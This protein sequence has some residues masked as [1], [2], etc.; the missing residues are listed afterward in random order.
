MNIDLITMGEM[1]IDFIPMQKGVPLKQNKGFYRMPG[2]APANVAV[3]A[4]KLG[5]KSAF[6]GK[7]GDDP[8]GDLLVDTLAENRVVTDYIVKTD[9]AHTALAFVTLAENGERDFT[10][11][12]NPSADMLYIWEEVDQKALLSAKIFHHGSISL[13]D[14]P[15]KTTTFKMVK[16]ARD[17]GLL[18][19]YDPNLR[20]PLWS[21]KET[22]RRT[23]KQ[24]LE[25]ADILKISEDEL[26]FITKEKDIGNGIEKLSK[27][28]IPYIF[29]TA[30][31]EG[32][33]Y[34]SNNYQGHQP[35]IEVK[36]E[37]T[38]GA[39]DAFAAAILTQFI[40]NDV[41]LGEDISQEKLVSMVKYANVAGGIA[42]TGKGAIASL[43]DQKMVDKIIKGE[44]L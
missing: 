24:G 4:A 19:S 33:Y 17:N 6:F 10:F 43:P 12:R 39:G 16:M 32:T 1:L 41:K 2:G 28:K 14:E 38:T 42:T 44:D 7:V 13:I 23:I 21:D 25:T 40:K 31:K 34:F 18:I 36:V 20:L 11:Y 37:D 22:A 9:V 26:E 35:A 3:G 27:Y 29:I 30:G 8:F 5:A 15:V